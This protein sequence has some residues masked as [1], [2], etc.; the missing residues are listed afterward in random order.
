MKAYKYSDLSIRKGEYD[1]DE[2][3]DDEYGEVNPTRQST[4]KKRTSIICG[5]PFFLFLLL[6]FLVLGMAGFLMLKDDPNH[7]LLSKLSLGNDMEQQKD[8]MEQQ[9]DDS[10]DY[11]ISSD[12]EDEDSSDSEDEDSSDSEDSSDENDS[13]E[14]DSSITSVGT[15]ASSSSGDDKD[16]SRSDSHDME[17][18][19]KELP[20]FPDLEGDNVNNTHS[21]AKAS[22]VV[23]DRS[24]IVEALKLKLQPKELY[25]ADSQS[26]LHQFL[27]LHQMKTGGTSMDHRLKCAMNRLKQDKNLTFSYGNIHECSQTRYNRC[28]D[29]EDPACMKR[30]TN[31]S[32]LSYCAPLKD[33]KQFE[34]DTS[35]DDIR[36]ITVLRNPVDRVWSMFRFQTKSCYKCMNLTH[37]YD[38]IDQGETDEFKDICM[39]QLM[40]HETANMLSQTELLHQNN[41]EYQIEPR[42]SQLVTEAVDN[43]KSFFTAIGLTEE[44]EQTVNLFGAIFSWFQTE[45]EWSDKTCDLTH[46]NSSPSNNRCGADGKSHLELPSTPDEE[47]RKAIEEH[48]QLDIA[49]YEAAVQHFQHQ[50]L[51][52]FGE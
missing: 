37:V 19:A 27:H 41:G 23:E 51:A 29:G 52:V 44:L 3:F 18:P 1:S 42:A 26:Y 17:E 40:N 30:I 32:I 38:L 48:N 39:K 16:S 50:N 28:R 14:G 36:A 8:D 2:D 6:I 10:S 49:V 47:T 24:Q 13:T 45:V 31:A 9:K 15:T 4:P 5:W 25:H 12:S 33:L 21:K 34:W 22:K 35:T 20:E 11:K 46:D 7:S 43:M